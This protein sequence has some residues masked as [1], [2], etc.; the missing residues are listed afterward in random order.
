MG[1]GKH[2]SARQ[3]PRVIT[4]LRRAEREFDSLSGGIMR[5]S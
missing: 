4:E 1:P 2:R 3:Q 5:V